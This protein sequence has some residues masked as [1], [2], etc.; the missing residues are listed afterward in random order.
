M[1]YLIFAVGF[2]LLGY[3]GLQWL[4][5]TSRDKALYGITGAAAIALLVVSLFLL[6]AGK[7]IGLILLPLGGFML[8]RNR[9]NAAGGSG[10]P[11][12]PPT[13]A[14]RMSD[15]EAREVL[16]VGPDASDEEIRSAHHK[17]IQ[18]VHPDHGGTS[19]LAA[20]I[21]EAKDVLLRR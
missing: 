2:I 11:G 9:R 14:G 16:G 10:R 1:V 12:T 3:L 4:A 19:Y 5:N 6:M 20:R 18:K 13:P 15:A 7:V 17:L 8:W 21:N